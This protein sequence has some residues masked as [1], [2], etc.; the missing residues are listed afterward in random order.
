M[1][2]E[3]LRLL[4]SGSHSAALTRR[5]LDKP[6]AVHLVRHQ[7]KDKQIEELP[8]DEKCSGLGNYVNQNC[9]IQ[10]IFWDS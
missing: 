2:E 8:D 4:R 9:V 6:V 3:G 5:H 10:L 7:L 1:T